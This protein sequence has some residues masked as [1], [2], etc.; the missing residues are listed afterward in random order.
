MW[1]GTR[2][3]VNHV[4][5]VFNDCSHGAE[6]QSSAI[7]QNLHE[8]AMSEGHLPEEFYIGADT[9]KETKNPYTFWF[10]I[11]LLCALD[12]TSLR[13]ICVVFLLVGHTHNKLDRL[14]SRISVALRGKDY[15]TVVGLL[16]RVRES[17][18]S[19][20]LRSS[21]LGQVWQWKA[22]CEGDMPGNKYRMHKLSTAHAFRF[23]RDNG[24]FMQRKQWSTDEAWSKPVQMFHRVGGCISEAKAPGR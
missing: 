3:V 8:V 21:H 4:R 6:M 15:F 16:A 7:L 9:P 20:D 5:T 23:S 18:R 14:L 24:I 2:Q 11:F 13:V 10:M 19:V 17:L 12:D 22:L 1:F